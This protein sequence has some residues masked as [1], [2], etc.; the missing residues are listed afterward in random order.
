MFRCGSYDHETDPEYERMQKAE[1]FIL[2]RY[3]QFLPVESADS[4]A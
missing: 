4:Q 1:S 2:S 3:H